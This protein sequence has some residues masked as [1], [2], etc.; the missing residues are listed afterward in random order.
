MDWIAIVL[1]RLYQKTLSP[2][3]GPLKVFFPDSYCRFHPTCSDYAI[4]AY[5]KHG[6]VKGSALAT[7]RVCRCNPWNDGGNDPVK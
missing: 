6:F 5:E 2:D 7:W 1:I 4:Q 3:H